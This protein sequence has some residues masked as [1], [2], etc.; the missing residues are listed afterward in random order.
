MIGLVIL[1]RH[2]YWNGVDLRTNTKIY[3]CFKKNPDYVLKPFSHSRFNSHYTW[4]CWDT[5]GTN[6]NVRINQSRFGNKWCGLEKLKFL[7]LVLWQGQWYGT[8]HLK[9]GWGKWSLVM[10]CNLL[11]RPIWLFKKHNTMY[12][13]KHDIHTSSKIYERIDYG[14]NLDSLIVSC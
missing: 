2:L 3:K 5:S 9:K 14:L 11:W 12:N 13:T 6:P 1:T 4:Y 10:L 8:R 7:I